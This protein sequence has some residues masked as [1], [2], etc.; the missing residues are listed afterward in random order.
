M[1]KNLL[2]IITII[3][4]VC[5]LI[6]GGVCI[7]S[8][9]H[10]ISFQGK[11]AIQGYLDNHNAGIFLYNRVFHIFTRITP[12]NML[13]FSPAWSPDGK[14]LAFVYSNNDYVYFHIAL[15]DISSGKIESLVD[16]GISDYLFNRDTALAW[17]PDGKQLL[18]DA[19]SDTC[20]ALFLYQLDQRNFHPLNIQ[21]CKSKTGDSVELVS[22][23]WSPGDAPLIGISYQGYYYYTD[24]IYLLK[25]P[26]T[27]SAWVIQGSDPVWRP[28]TDE[29]SYICKNPEKP[30]HNSLCIYSTGLEKSNE[31]FADY[32][33]DHYAW[34]PDGQFILYINTGYE[35]AS[36]S[37]LS[38]IDVKTGE[39]NTLLNLI[40]FYWS[41]YPG[42]FRW[43]D[44]EVSWSTK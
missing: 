13:V 41:V 40:H 31:I 7:A 26:F 3:I 23:S 35:E 43:V 10:G 9:L 11:I 37:L 20:H 4:V 42:Y 32:T 6:A 24:D 39:Q 34:S 21:F 38:L 17:S 14:K 44:G 18:F 8:Q 15:L 36:P 33:Y 30:Y 12:Q 2:R 29:F 1:K 25:P 27:R 22:L 16:K 5:F 28:G 19:A